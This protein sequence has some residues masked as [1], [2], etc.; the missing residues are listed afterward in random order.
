MLKQFGCQRIGN[1]STDTMFISRDIGLNQG[2]VSFI[3]N[4][5][6]KRIVLAITMLAG[7]GKEFE[8]RVQ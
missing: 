3:F 1:I 4:R 7:T 6:G 8:D 2:T 5:V